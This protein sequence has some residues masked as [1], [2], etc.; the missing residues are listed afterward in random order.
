MLNIIQVLPRW[1]SPSIVK[2]QSRSHTDRNHRN[3]EQFVCALQF[4][5]ECALGNL[6]VSPALLCG[7]RKKTNLYLCALLFSHNLPTLYRAEAGARRGLGEVWSFILIQTASFWKLL[8]LTRQSQHEVSWNLE[9][10][11]KCLSPVGGPLSSVFCSTYCFCVSMLPLYFLTCFSHSQ[12]P[13][14]SPVF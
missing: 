12:F 5:L 10:L 9:L 8:D 7:P 4:G 3:T 1:S 13:L 11:Q 6:G 14:T 2:L